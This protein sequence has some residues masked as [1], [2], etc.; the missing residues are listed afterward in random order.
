MT[1]IVPEHA[2]PS[3]P[4]TVFHFNEH[5]DVNKCH[6]WQSKRYRISCEDEEN[7]APRLKESC[8]SGFMTGVRA[9]ERSIAK[10]GNSIV[11]FAAN[12]AV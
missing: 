4:C 10:K 3:S 1:R 11:C 2:L 9:N 6:V 7:T 12:G 8:H 5:L